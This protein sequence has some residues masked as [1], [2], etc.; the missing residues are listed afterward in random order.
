MSGGGIGG[1]GTGCL[2]GAVIAVLITTIV[3]VIELSYGHRFAGGL[4][5]LPAVIVVC[6]LAW[7]GLRGTLQSMSKG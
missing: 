2:A 7:A 5:L 4:L 1:G 3:G 6:F